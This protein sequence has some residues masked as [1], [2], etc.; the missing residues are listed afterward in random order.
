MK[1]IEIT[2][3]DSNSSGLAFPTTI[4]ISNLAL[5]IDI[6]QAPKGIAPKRAETMIAFK[7]DEESCYVLE[8]YSTVRALVKAAIRNS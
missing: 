3:V 1:L 2:A 5:I 7:G 6:S 8:D 4:E